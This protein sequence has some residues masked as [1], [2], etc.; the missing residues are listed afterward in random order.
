MQRAAFHGGMAVFCKWCFGLDTALWGRLCIHHISSKGPNGCLHFLPAC[1]KIESH[2]KKSS[3]MAHASSDGFVI[4]FNLKKSS[5]DE[6][7]LLSFSAGWKIYNMLMRHCQKQL[8]SLGQ[9]EFAS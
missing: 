6:I 9:T 5:V 8:V 1:A 4:E 2:Y 3:D 7:Y